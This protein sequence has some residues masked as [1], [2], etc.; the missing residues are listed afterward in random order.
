MG[1]GNGNLATH[2]TSTN[3]EIA[4]T[5][6]HFNIIFFLNVADMTSGDQK[7]I[8]EKFFELERKEG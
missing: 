7:G 6:T 4:I 8:F 2:A 3:H 1:Y 5:V